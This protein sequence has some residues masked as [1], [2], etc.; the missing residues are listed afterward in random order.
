MTFDELRETEIFKERIHEVEGSVE[1]TLMLW[2]H[3]GFAYEPSDDH[4][5][6][7][8]GEVY[9]SDNMSELLRDLMNLPRCQCEYCRGIVN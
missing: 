6:A 1:G 8:H 3:R 9:D 7:R 4:D 5:Q 2:T